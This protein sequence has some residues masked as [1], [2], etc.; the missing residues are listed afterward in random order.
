MGELFHFY[1]LKRFRQT[2]CSYEVQEMNTA[3]PIKILFTLLLTLFCIDA[4]PQDAGL[5]L[6]DDKRNDSI[7][8]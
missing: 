2:I 3:T 4:S 6:A 8:T 7:I 1:F 5:T